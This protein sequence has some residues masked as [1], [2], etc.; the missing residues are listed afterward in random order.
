MAE[1]FQG[2]SRIGDQFPDKD[3]FLGIEGID[4]YIEEFFGFCFKFRGYSLACHGSPL[5]M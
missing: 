5:A 1:F 4:H 3:I 2:I